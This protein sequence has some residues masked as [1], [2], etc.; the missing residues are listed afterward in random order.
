MTWPMVPQRPAAP[1]AA[2]RPV[3]PMGIVPYVVQPG[4]TVFIIAQKFRTSMAAI[5][6]ANCLPNPDLINVGQVLYIP[7]PTAAPAAMPDPGLM[8]AP[9]MPAADPDES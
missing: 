9:P 2:R 6:G 1:Y 8:W 4:D 7:C 5:I 3:G